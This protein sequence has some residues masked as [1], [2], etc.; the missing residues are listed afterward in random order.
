LM[1]GS[2]SFFGVQAA[3]SDAPELWFA[4]P[5]IAPVRYS[6]AETL[7]ADAVATVAGLRAMGLEVR[8]LSGD[9]A[10]PVARAAV[11]LGIAD[12]RAGC[13]P[14]DKLAVLEALRAEGRRV[15]MVGDGLN[16]A[17][18][19]AAAYVSMS[20]SSAADISQNAA[21]VVFQ[22]ARLGPVVAVLRMARRAQA[23]MREN[24][25]LSIGYNVVMVPL[26][27]AGMVTP[28][29]AAASMSASSLLVMVNALR[30]RRCKPF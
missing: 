24:I 4:A 25:A 17:P 8:L 22:G 14:Q 21:D 28:W 6:F 20:P 1:L 15:L 18:G 5:G 11:A 9:R 27:M 23:V 30:V 10:E 19:L 16:D 13:A 3:S 29:V 7:R 12:A 2:Q 26:A